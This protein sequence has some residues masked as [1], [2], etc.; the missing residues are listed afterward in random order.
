MK[1]YSTQMKTFLNKRVRAA[2]S[3]AIMLFC[4]MIFVFFAAAADAQVPGVPTG[5]EA[6]PT[7]NS[8]TPPINLTWD[9]TPGATSYIVYRSTTSNGETQY[10]TSTSNSYLDSNVVAGPPTVYY[11]R[12]AAVNAS[13]TGLQS[14]ESATP[15]PLPT[16]TGDGMQAGISLG[17][18]AYQ[19]NAEYALRDGFDW[20]VALNDWFPEILGSTGSISPGQLVV[21][22]AYASE[23]TMSFLNVNV[24]T[25]G[26]YNIDWSYAFASGAFPFV[27]NRE[28]SLIVNGVHITDHQ[29]FPIT[30]SFDI[31]QDS[32][33]QAQLN[34]GVNSIVMAGVS[35]WGVS[36]VDTLT[37]SPASGSVPAGPTSLSATPGNGQ[38]Q[39]S[40]NGASDADSYNIYR[41]NTV[42][43]GESL[44]PIATV[45]SGTTTYTDTDVNN[46]TFYFYQ[47]AAVN[48]FGIGPDSNEVT[49]TPAAGPLLSQGQPVTAS[50][51]QTDNYPFYGNDVIPTT[52][53]AAFNSTYPQW[54][55]VDLGSSKSIN[56]AV[57]DWYNPNGRAYKY[58]IETSPDD[59]TYALLVDKTSNTTAGY[60]SDAFSATTRYVRITVTG[61]NPAG[62][63]ASFWECSIYGDTAPPPAPTGLTATAVSSSQINLSWTASSGATSYNVKRATVS[64]GPYTTVATGLT[65]TSYSDTGLAASTTYY[66][67]VSA[68]NS[69][70]ESANSTEASATTPTPDFTIAASPNSQTVTAGCG[71]SYTTTITAVNGFTGTVSL[72]VS[73]LPSGATGSFNP[74]SVAGSGN[75]TLSVSTSSTTPAGTYTLTITGASG[76]LTHSASVTLVVN[77]AGGTVLLSQGQQTSASSFQSGN[78]P[79]NGNDGLLTTRWAAANNTYPQWWQV[80]LGTSHIL[81]Q[82]VINWYK[83]SSRAYQYR[84]ET[85]NDNVTFTTVVDQ[86]AR[87]STGDSTDNFSATGRYVRITVTGVIGGGWASFWECQ[88][89]GTP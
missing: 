44:T 36:R 41:G 66:Y 16:S 68:V 81:S 70:G 86:A 55:R 80:D 82:V 64:G 15:T 89:Y 60:T 8:G 3:R 13:G 40:W 37:V 4:S 24:P 51:F 84:I 85:S 79:A 12:V 71:T 65:A 2:L 26:L 62:G 52:R 11:Y 17:G 5:V 46:G 7:S 27:K 22:M 1:K 73:G 59:V 28:M 88:V 54:W 57:I 32:V 74:T 30:G 18:G 49:A 39:L 67:V 25:S 69:A 10:A 76:S 9:P 6:H 48:S 72:S 20:F 42:S 23:G 33:L 34:A 31:Y 83:S 38:V 43:D 14:L 45:S 50:T 58:K 78:V 77:A 87:T 19:W 47:V 75:S 61:V 35:H 63:N 53:W 21:D 56:Q 29:R